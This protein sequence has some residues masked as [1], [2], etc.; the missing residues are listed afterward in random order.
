MENINPV[1]EESWKAV[2]MKEFTKPYFGELVD[3]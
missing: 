3:P 1:I 2:L